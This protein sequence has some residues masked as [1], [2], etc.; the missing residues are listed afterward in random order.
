MT[1]D[2]N[3]KDNIIFVKEKFGQEIWT[4]VCGKN[5]Q[6]GDQCLFR[7]ILIPENEIDFELKRSDWSSVDDILPGLY[8]IEKEEYKYDRF[9]GSTY[10][11]IVYHRHFHGVKDDY[12]DISQEFILLN[13]LYYDKKNDEYCKIKDNGETETIVKIDG[14]SI[15]IRTDYIKKFLAVKKNG[16]VL[17][18]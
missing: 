7:G 9:S 10:E 3:Q 17:K 4:Q 2:F 6:I 16:N 11:P 5:D 15:F 14:L 8:S 18:F 12:I 1:K 13:N